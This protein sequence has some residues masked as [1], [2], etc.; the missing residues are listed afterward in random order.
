MTTYISPEKQQNL[1]DTSIGINSASSIIWLGRKVLVKIEEKAIG[2][3]YYQA[4]VAKIDNA[5]LFLSSTEA[6]CKE[7][8]INL[9]WREWKGLGKPAILTV[10]L[11]YIIKEN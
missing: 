7:N 3:L 11:D 6:I 4:S 1:P 9:L 8:C 5:K 2:I 10:E